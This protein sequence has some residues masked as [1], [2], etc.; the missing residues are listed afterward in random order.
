MKKFFSYFADF[1]SFLKKKVW[2]E[3]ED[4]FFQNNFGEETRP[5]V[6]AENFETK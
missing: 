6:E 5:H 3:P 4:N 1:F 2:Y